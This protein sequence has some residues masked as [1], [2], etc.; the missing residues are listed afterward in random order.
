MTTWIETSVDVTVEIAFVSDPWATTPTWTDVSAYVRDIETFRGTTSED[1]VIGPGS[2]RV[3]LDN[4]LRRFDPDY[5]AGPY[6]GNLVP[7]KRMRVTATRAAVTFTVFLGWVTGWQQEWNV[8]DGVA[9]ADASDGS[10]QLQS[11]MLAV[12]AYD[13][14]CD[15]DGAMYGWQLDG[16]LVERT[17]IDS[18]LLQPY[19]SPVDG[20]LHPGDFTDFGYPVGTTLAHTGQLDGALEIA[21]SSALDEALSVEFWLQL[22]STATA[23]QLTDL[24]FEIDHKSAD[25]RINIRHW[26]ADS[27]FSGVKN[28]TNWDI[29]F[30]STTNNDSVSLTFDYPLTRGVPHHIAIVAN[31]TDLRFYLNGELLQTATHTGTYSTTWDPSM[32]LLQYDTIMMSGLNFYSG[33]LTA[34]QVAEHYSAGL[35]AYGHPINE[36]GGT[37]M[38]RVLNDVAYPANLR[39]ISSGGTVQGPYE[40]AGM[41]V[42]DYVY[43]ILASE[44][45]FVFWSVDGKFTFRSRQWQWIDADTTAV[46]FSDDGGAG[47]VRYQNG[48]PNSGTI[49]TVRNIVTTS[50]STVGGITRRDA[51]SIT[52]YGPSS[53]FIDAPT[54]RNGTDASNLSAYVLRLKKDPQRTIP[55]LTVPLRADIATNFAP[56]LGIELGDVVTVERTPMGVGS[57]IV[58]RLQVLAI[59]HSITPANWETELYMSPAIPMADEV[60]YLTIAHATYGRVGAPAGNAIPF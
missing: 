7:M 18:L 44:R 9:Y 27:T 26:Y 58:E 52:A 1:L 24:A 6:F 17:G 57:Q 28:A 22:P 4:R 50:Y 54:L 10:G 34:G 49:D 40:P 5:S 15:I 37:R 14:Q 32:W 46:T 20:A 3:T 2:L 59:R 51:A 39:D 21:T 47:A 53:E 13:A 31:A 19:E 23:G 8:G 48:S 12:T 33:S 25:A 30:G 42:M 43:Q 55:R 35:H 45:G 29:D 38:E 41:Q 36:T 56:V 11:E 60:P 16:N